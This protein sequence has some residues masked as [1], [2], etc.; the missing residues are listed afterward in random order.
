MRVTILGSGAAG[1]VPMVSIGWGNCDYNEPRNRRLRPSILIEDEERVILI[2]TSP[3]LRAQLLSANVCRLDAV[4]YTHTHADHMHGIDDLREINM[5]MKAPIDVYGTTDALNDIKTRFGYVFDPLD[6]TTMPIY[7]PWLIPHQLNEL[8]HI[9]TTNVMSFD[10]IHGHTKTVG[11]RFN[12]IA[13]STDVVELSEKSLAL[14]E[15]LNLWIVGCPSDI[16]QRTHAHLS[17]V[18][19]WAEHLRPKI[20][21]ICHMSPRLDYG[22]LKTHL[23]NGIIPAYDGLI[24]EV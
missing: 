18:I 19:T 11:F 6:L 4:L 2:D 15:N 7:K 17:K 13:Y 16:P 9:G 21:L 23:P 14:L 1:G 22:Y 12:H 8:F 20:T 5:I 24:I 10:Q 3:D